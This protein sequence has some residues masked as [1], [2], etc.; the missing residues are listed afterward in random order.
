MAHAVPPTL[1]SATGSSP[2]EEL[3]AARSVLRTLPIAGAIP[4]T[5]RRVMVG[6]STSRR[7]SRADSHSGKSR[8]ACITPAVPLQAVSLLLGVRVRWGAWERDDYQTRCS[9]GRIRNPQLQ[10]GICECGS[11]LRPD[12]GT[13]SLLLGR[14]LH[15]PTWRWDHNQTSCPGRRADRSPIFSAGIPRGSHVCR[16]G[17]HRCGLLLGEQQPWPGRRRHDKLAAP[18]PDTSGRSPVGRPLLLGPRPMNGAPSRGSVF[19]LAIG[20]VSPASSGPESSVPR[21]RPDRVAPH[22]ESLRLSSRGP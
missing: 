13:Q 20:R 19:T 17:R 21:T 1:G 14:K 18:S 7:P 16:A 4:T 3:T 5:D 2:Q 9:P 11:H 10:P 6:P 22:G 8:P 12:N 15:R